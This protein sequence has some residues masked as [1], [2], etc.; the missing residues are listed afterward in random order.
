MQ[1]EEVSLVEEDFRTRTTGIDYSDVFN[2]TLTTKPDF[3]SF[4]WLLSR[5]VR[6]KKK[7]YGTTYVLNTRRWQLL[8]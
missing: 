8:Y 2:Q 3:K 1:A 6:A 4:P 5:Y 7:I